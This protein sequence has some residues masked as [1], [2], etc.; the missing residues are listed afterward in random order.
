MAES[1][2]RKSSLELATLDVR[3][4]APTRPKSW[5]N[6]PLPEDPVEVSTPGRFDVCRSRERSCSK[7]SAA[8]TSY[9]I[10][11]SAAMSCL[12]A[13]SRY[14]DVSRRSGRRASA[15]SARTVLSWSS[16]A[17][18]TTSCASAL[19]SSNL[20]TSSASLPEPLTPWS[21]KEPM[22]ALARPPLNG[23]ALPKVERM[24]L[25]LSLFVGEVRGVLIP[26]APDSIL[27]GMV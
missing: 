22:L 23:R 21:R 12:A 13:S 27:Q 7:R 4:V 16:S 24:G 19:G 3:F 6:L 15:S 9:R 18:C 5:L 17:L 11:E 1:C 2:R 14:T 20:K 26:R 25:L 8:V 10:C